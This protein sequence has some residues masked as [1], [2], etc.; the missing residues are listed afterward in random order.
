MS[1]SLGAALLSP[2]TLPPIPEPAVRRLESELREFGWHIIFNEEPD[3][4]WSWR[5]V[6]DHQDVLGSGTADNW[7]DT[8]LNSIIDL[9]PP[10]NE[11]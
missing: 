6:D 3:D 5:V 4:S 9:M 11:R 1:D 8:K 7:D 10:S 2:P